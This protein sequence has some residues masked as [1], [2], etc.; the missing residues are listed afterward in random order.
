[1]A[2]IGS[3]ATAVTLVP[4]IAK[5]AKHVTMVQR[6]PTYIVAAPAKDPIANTLSKFLPPSVTHPMMRWKNIALGTATFNLMQAYP[7]ASKKLLLTRAWDE[8]KGCMPREDF[9]KHFTPPYNPWDQRLCLT[10]A[11][12]LFECI[13]EGR[14]S[15]VTDH[16]ETFTEYGILMKSGEHVDADIIVTATGLTLQRNFPMSTMQVTVDGAPYV[17]SQKLVYKGMMLSGVPNFAFTVGY[18]NASWTLKADL[19]S[20]YVC[21]LLNHMRL[22]KYSICSPQADSSTEVDN[23]F[24]SLTSGYVTR[25]QE[26]MPN[27]G[28]KAPWR[29]YNNYIRD[30]MQLGWSSLEDSNMKFAT[31]LSRL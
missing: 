27:Q 9:V 29:L 15:I 1:V 26:H 14:A 8:L 20:A 7:E 12:D 16:I 2:V 11:G 30:R 22:K 5:A 24:L 18:T 21:R 31:P 17:A 6:T 19:T 25:A 10:P 3:G 28:T 4:N 23:G 13:R